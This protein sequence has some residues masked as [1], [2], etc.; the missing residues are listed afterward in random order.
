MFRNLIAYAD[1][2]TMAA[3]ALS[4]SVTI[5]NYR[6]LRKIFFTPKFTL[7]SCLLI[8]I[9]A[10]LIISPA[11]FKFSVA[12]FSFG[13]FGWDIVAGKCEVF[14]C[15]HTDGIKPGGVIYIYGVFTPLLIILISYI[16]LGVFVQ[17]EIRGLS[18][19]RASDSNQVN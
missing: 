3:I 14:N 10:F 7:C 17:K 13:Y 18:S 5:I 16:F 11:T 2:L 1:F 8:W 6:C 19:G 9:L 4:R 15:D 12:G